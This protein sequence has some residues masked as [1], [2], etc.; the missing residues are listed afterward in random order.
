MDIYID[1]ETVPGQAPELRDQIR[2]SI[3]A[4]AQY[5]KPESIA[6]WL[7]NEG[8]AA[9]EEKWR[10]TALNGTYGQVFCVAW[11]IGDEPVRSAR[12]QNL[13][14]PE[15]R[16]LLATLFAGLKPPP[17]EHRSP[18]IIGHNVANF[19]LRFIL[20][21]AIVNQVRP[22]IWWPRDPKPWSDAVVDTMTAWSGAKGSVS[23]DD[24]CRA[25][26]IAGKG[27]FSGADVWPAVQAGQ[28]DKVEAYCRDDVERVRAIHR[29]LE[30]R[31]VA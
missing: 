23:L 22:P 9:A 21:R 19:D 15:E 3:K 4:P 10:S 14:R 8:E 12:V 20:Q 5:K 17:N 11:A 30:F 31:E 1:I 24:L 28:F 13:S 27:D 29:F 16:N 25:L 6:E 26:G 2:A 7:K 18:R